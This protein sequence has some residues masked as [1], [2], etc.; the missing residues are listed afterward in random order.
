ML[1]RY[2]FF[3]SLAVLALSG[4]SNSRTAGE[5]SRAD[6]TKESPSLGVPGAQY[7]GK[8]GSLAKPQKVKALVTAVDFQERSITLLPAKQGQQFR[9]ADLGDK[10]REWYSVP[11]L[12]LTFVVPAGL[13]KIGASKK[14][15][16]ALGKKTMRLEDVGVGSQ[17]QVEYYPVLRQI[18]KMRLMRPPS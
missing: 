12:Q 1:V 11:E 18:L 5:I 10:G 17:V 7:T 15:A 4:Q 16:K 13:E 8:L 14:A 6:P 2:L 9:V 3:A